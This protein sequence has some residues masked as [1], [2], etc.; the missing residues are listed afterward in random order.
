MTIHSLKYLFCFYKTKQ[1]VTDIGHQAHQY[2]IM[3]MERFVFL[4]LL[5]QLQV[6][7][8][9]GFV[10]VPRRA[11]T[12]DH[13]VTST[14]VLFSTP[15]PSPLPSPLPQVRNKNKKQNA[16]D[17]YMTAMRADIERMREEAAQRL[18]A[19]NEK[20]IVVSKQKEEQ[21][22]EAEAEAAKATKNNNKK[23]E[24][25]TMESLT[26]I[27]DAFER[28]MN[29]INSKLASK[30][31]PEEDE[32]EEIYITT[33]TTTTT[34]TTDNTTTR[35]K[36]QQQQQHPLKLLDD[37]RWRLMLNVGRVP[38]TWMPKTWGASG[39]K[40]H[41][42]L[43]VEFTAEELYERE[44][45]FNGLSDGSKVLRVIKNEASLAPCMTEGG[46][47]VRVVDGGWRV[48]SHEGPLG[49]SV[50]RFYFNIEEETRHLG[51]DV[52]LPCGRV[53]GTC[54]YFP[55]TARSNVDG[56][57]TSRKENYKQ[58]LRQLEVNYQSLQS[59][60]DRDPDL[61][62]F[63]KLKRFTK[64]RDIRRDVKNIR[65]AID[66]ER[67]REPKK[68]ALRLS[69]DSSVGLTQEGGICCKTITQHG[70]S[71]EYH[72]LGKFQAASMENREH[73]DYRDVLLP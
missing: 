64:M 2:L 53:Y 70:L 10:Q 18:E 24:K 22:A 40:L 58:E 30:L 36:Q 31:F 57:G 39:E 67:I 73:S 37:T 65:M 55:M 66:E 21:E 42:K 1:Q 71:Y 26:E 19:L 23:K 63:D 43:E 51:S 12:T 44:D 13:P 5:V 33:T 54:G 68:S 32:E 20:L 7:F 27:A 49:T 15:S 35:Q 28:D 8:G 45:F 25:Q 38:G 41:L 72:I 4:L 3:I 16:S 46:R 6:E 9:L 59:D 47:T 52:Y 61:V 29:R 56:R 14:V 60:M 11:T 69:Q 17:E 62:S 34:T 48:A 50:L